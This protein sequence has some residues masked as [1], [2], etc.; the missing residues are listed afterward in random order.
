MPVKHNKLEIAYSAYLASLSKGQN[1]L[2]RKSFLDT[3]VTD[4][5]FR[6]IFGK[7]IT[8]PLSL[9]ERLK[10]AYPDSEER[11]QTL[12]FLGTA[13]M[14]RHLNH[15]KIP[16]RRIGRKRKEVFKFINNKS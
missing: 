16:D 8:R 9:D 12:I 2:D 11:V 4:D 14:K 1:P 15:L 6:K 7:D 5:D 3:L 10:I 13:S